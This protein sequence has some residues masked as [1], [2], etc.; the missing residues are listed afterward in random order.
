M[1]HLRFRGKKMDSGSETSSH[2]IVIDIKVL[3]LP[4]SRE[5]LPPQSPSCSCVLHAS[6][7]NLRLLNA[8]TD[9]K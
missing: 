2:F 7:W 4:T 5:A 6:L 3:S 9:E 1:T 8:L